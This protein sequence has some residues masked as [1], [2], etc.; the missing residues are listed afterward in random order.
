V[1]RVNKRTRRRTRH[2][3]VT[4]RPCGLLHAILSHKEIHEDNF[5]WVTYSASKVDPQPISPIPIVINLVLSSSVVTSVVTAVSPDGSTKLAE[6]VL[7]SN[8]ESGQ[9]TEALMPN[10]SGTQII[11]QTDS[12]MG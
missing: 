4:I 8:A 10:I 5:R 6:S 7:K 12:K 11:L 9:F 3:P 1:R 2:H